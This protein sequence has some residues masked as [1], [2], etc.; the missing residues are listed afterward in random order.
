MDLTKTS[1]VNMLKVRVRE[2]SLVLCSDT[3]LMYEYAA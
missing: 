2:Q 1:A 3:L